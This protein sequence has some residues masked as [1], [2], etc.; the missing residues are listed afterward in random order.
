MKRILIIL[1]AAICLVG[2]VLALSSINGSSVFRKNVE[3]LAQQARD[4]VCF[5]IVDKNG[6]PL[7]GA[8][9]QVKGTMRGV[10]ADIDGNV[11]IEVA[12]GEVLV[13]SYI[14]YMSVEITYTGP[15]S[16]EQIILEEDD[17]VLDE[18]I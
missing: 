4:R 16:I 11:C 6:D 3:T 18:V 17:E 1:S 2:G 8:S 15:G 14:G 7:I 9:V 10:M 12:R 5:K 13:I